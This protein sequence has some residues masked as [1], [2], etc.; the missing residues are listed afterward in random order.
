[1][2]KSA[3]DSATA[4]HAA[5]SAT[6]LAVVRRVRAD[7]LSLPDALLPPAGNPLPLALPWPDTAPLPLAPP[8]PV[9]TC[10]RA[11]AMTASA[12]GT[13]ALRRRFRRRLGRSPG[14]SFRGAPPLRC[15]S[16]VTDAPPHRSWTLPIPSLGID[17]GL[18]DGAGR[19]FVDA[20]SCFSTP[21]VRRGEG[22]P[23][24]HGRQSLVPE[25]DGAAGGVRDPLRQDARLPGGLPFPSAHVE[26]KADDEPA[27]VL[28]VGQFAQR[29]E[30]GRR[31]GRVEGGARMGQEPEF[32]V[33]RDTDSRLP[34]VEPAGSARTPRVGSHRQRLYP[35]H[36]ARAIVRGLDPAV[37]SGR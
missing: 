27:D 22:A 30:E 28:V 7:A 18:E 21:D 37:R 29:D 5:P 14:G 17:P 31:I 6:A 25:L 11:R 1:M 36:G 19:C 35:A 13:E 34:R 24:L 12:G 23:G 33:D 16:S 4:T 26:R 9:G 10:G 20:R 3:M 2:A 32:V 8:E 15:S